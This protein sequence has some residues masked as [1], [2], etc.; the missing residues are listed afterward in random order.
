MSSEY[1]DILRTIG[2]YF[3][4]EL[5]PL[6][7]IRNYKVCLN[8]RKRKPYED[9]VAYVSSDLLNV[10]TI[11]IVTDSED[12]LIAHLI[13]EYFHVYIADYFN[14]IYLVRGEWYDEKSLR[15]NLREYANVF[16]VIIRETCELAEK[17]TIDYYALNW[18]EYYVCKAPL[19]SDLRS[20]LK[21]LADIFYEKQVK[22]HIE[23]LKIIISK[24]VKM[25]WYKSCL[26]YTSP[27]PRDLSTSRMPSSA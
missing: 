14:F 4:K 13:H 23:D 6:F 18:L 10:I 26:L 3:Y 25:H 15:C 11:T 22:P 20:D 7:P 9:E 8:I 1:E 16:R 27:S 24:K 21:F 12:N 2:E 5:A 19:N 17:L